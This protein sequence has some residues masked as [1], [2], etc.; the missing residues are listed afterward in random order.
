MLRIS[1]IKNLP[2]DGYVLFMLGSYAPFHEG[3]DDAITSA[4]RAF[5]DAGYK[6]AGIVIVPHSDLYVGNKIHETEWNIDRRIDSILDSKISCK[7]PLYLDDISH[8]HPALK[9]VNQIV[10]GTMKRTGIDPSRI[11][12]VVG[13]DNLKSM[14]PYISSHKVICL[15]RPGYETSLSILKANESFSRNLPNLII[16]NR[17]R[18]SDDISSSLIRVGKSTHD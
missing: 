11:V 17:Q 8:R 15:R 5:L 14:A 6:I 18:A 7:S 16:A 13:A 2:P 3:H 4:E 1:R 9:K 12:I 10:L